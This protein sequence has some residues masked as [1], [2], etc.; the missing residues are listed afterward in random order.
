MAKKDEQAEALKNGPLGV[1]D[2]PSAEAEGRELD[3]AQQARA[4][5]HY[6]VTGNNELGYIDQSRD[7]EPDIGAEFGQAPHPEL[8]NPEPHADAKLSGSS[9]GGVPGIGEKNDSPL[10]N[11]DEEQA[12]A[13]REK[14][15]EDAQARA[16]GLAVGGVVVAPGP[17]QPVVVVEDRADARADAKSDAKSDSK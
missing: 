6:R 13:A 8:F 12:K 5:A 2:V 7:Q 14:A 15:V 11:P 4:L 16:E 10:V 17:A 1:E 9:S 3:H